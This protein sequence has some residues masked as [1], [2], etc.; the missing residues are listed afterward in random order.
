MRSSLLFASSVALA[1]LLSVSSARAGE[2]NDDRTS[3][4][5]TH[6]EGY[7]SPSDRDVVR[8][9]DDA[10][11]VKHVAIEA[12]P[13]GILVGHYS[14]QVETMIAPHSALTFNPHFDYSHWE[15][16]DMLGGDSSYAGFGSEVGYRFYTARS[17]PAG[18][19]VGPSLLGGVYRTYRSFGGHTF[20]MVGAALDVGAQAVL[21]PVVLGA[22]IGVQYN[23]S[24]IDY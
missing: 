20:P 14:L 17:K 22:G 24:G 8:A 5:T 23:L 15:A 9:N 7:G 2:P 3:V 10:P 1:S 19:F 11:V 4:V 12:N 21:G 18:L 6:V 16:Q 13:L